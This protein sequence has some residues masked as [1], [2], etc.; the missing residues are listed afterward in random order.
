[1]KLPT[2]SADDGSGTGKMDCQFDF[3]VSKEVASSA[4]VSGSIGYRQRG[5]PD[6][7][8][9]SSGIPFG[10][11]AQFPTRSPLKF[12]TEWCGE[13][14]NNDV[15]T[16][17]VSPAPASIIGVDGS[18]PLGH[19]G[20]S[21]AVD[22]DVRRDLADAARG[23]SRRRHQL[24]GQGRR[25]R[26]SR[27]RQRRQLRHEVRLAV[28]HRLSPRRGRHPGPA[29]AAAAAATAGAGAAA[30][31]DRR[32]AVQ[33]VHGRSRRDVEGDGDRED[34]IGC[35]ITYQWSAPTGTFANPAQQNTAWTAPNTPGTVP[36]TVT[37]TC[38][39]DKH[40]GVRHGQH[41][42]RAARR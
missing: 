29:A 11:G 3:I 30:H 22:A 24:V 41:P 12:T 4:E 14:F 28:P 19:V 26:G 27:R 16:R 1:M 25:S 15:V 20:S 21:A 36:V 8:D 23:S 13:I 40:E 32:C 31:A 7:Y 35:V 10:I 18:V 9:L 6:E 38:P 34:S 33:S 2:G 37:G 42:G 17:T 5:D 39:T